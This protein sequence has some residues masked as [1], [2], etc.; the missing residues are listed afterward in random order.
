MESLFSSWQ[1]TI[2]LTW[3]YLT[4]LDSLRTLINLTPVNNHFLLYSCK[5]YFMVHNKFAFIEPCYSKDFIFIMS[6]NS[7][8]CIRYYSFY[9]LVF[10]SQLAVLRD[11]SWQ[12]L[13]DN[14]GCQ[15]S[16]AAMQGKHIAYCTVS[17]P[18]IF[19]DFWMWGHTY[20]YTLL[21]MQSVNRSWLV[22]GTI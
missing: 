5:F 22:L 10:R 3:Q 11:H 4:F 15:G 6:F 16:N 12:F 8:L 18:P 19:I 13:R 20:L 2:C 17:S 21:A 9:F 7:H 14:I 1:S